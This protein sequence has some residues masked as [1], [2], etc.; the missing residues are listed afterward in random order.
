MKRLFAILFAL[1]CT[2]PLFC[3]DREV[4]SLLRVLDAS[5]QGRERYTLERQ[6]QINALQCQLKA[7]RSDAELLEIYQELFG[8][9]SAYRMD[10]A[11]W[12]ANRCVEVAQRMSVASHLYSAR[13]RVAEVMIGTGM[14][15][16]GLEILED[17]PQEEL[18]AI[19]M[20]YYY[21]LYHKVYTLMASYAFSEELQAS[22]S[23]L[24]YQYKDSILRVKRPDSQGYQLTLGDKLLYEG[25]YDEAIG[26]LEGCYDIHSQKDFSL[27]IPS[28]ALASVYGAKGDHKQEKKYL[29]ISAIAD[30]QSGTK[31]YISLWKLAN[32]L[33]GE[34]DIERAY[35]YME[36]SMQDATFCNARYRTMEISGMLPVINSTYEAKLHEEKEQLVT[37]FQGHE[38]ADISNDFIY[39]KK[40]IRCMT[41]LHLLII[42]RQMEVQILYIAAHLFQ[43]DKGADSCRIVETFAKLPRIT[44]LTEL[45]LQV[46]CCEVD[47]HRHRIVIAMR[48]T[49]CNVLSQTA[50]AY[51]HFR[52]VMHLI[53]KVGD[54]ERLAI[55]QN[56]RIGFQENNRFIILVCMSQLLVVQSIV[57]SYSNNL[58]YLISLKFSLLNI[59]ARWA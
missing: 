5:V 21:N 38:A 57:H 18:G 25:K 16:E 56:G 51:D 41:A 1:F 2:M 42:N 27:A 24:A 36:C 14:Y 45:T 22:Y 54:K 49:G 29:T 43:R 10:S 59:T 15:K 39:L 28:V 12:A 44:R 30:V 6:S 37:D 26:V 8:K 53:R 20:F 40:H 32:L 35:T 46:A 13:M 7:T 4:D 47:A 19:D 33:Y 11:L 9:Y 31:E 23:R 17:I 58:H 34:G 50:D 55:F 3:Q 52:L 48:K